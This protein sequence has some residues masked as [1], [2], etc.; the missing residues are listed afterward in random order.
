M[1]C[2]W[3]NQIR[4]K[5]SMFLPRVDKNSGNVLRLCGHNF[6]LVKGAFF[7]T[8]LFDIT[9]LIELHLF[10]MKLLWYA[11]STIKCSE[12]ACIICA[13]IIKC[14]DKDKSIVLHLSKPNNIIIFKICKTSIHSRPPLCINQFLIILIILIRNMRDFDISFESQHNFVGMI[15]IFNVMYYLHLLLSNSESGF[16]L[17]FHG[18]WSM[19]NNWP[20][21]LCYF[22][23]NALLLGV[24][25]S[26]EI[27]Y[28][29]LLLNEEKHV[30]LSQ[31][32][33]DDWIS[34]L[35]WNEKRINQ[36]LN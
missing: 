34:Y 11:L 21:S 15:I 28:R 29:H 20:E 10:N 4:S 25:K 5:I 36:L 19:K 1:W 9:S 18:S 35:I 27:N 7:T 26:L 30:I 23:I 8:L 6:R 31:C 32:I 16:C 14:C 24:W 2:A 12:P 3:I 33:I 17:S 13:I 22:N